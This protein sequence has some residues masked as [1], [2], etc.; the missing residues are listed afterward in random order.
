[1][2][3]SEAPPSQIA[4]N[5]E[6]MKIRLDH[7][8]E[9]ASTM[10]GQYGPSG[11]KTLWD[12]LEGQPV[13]MIPVGPDTEKRTPWEITLEWWNKSFGDEEENAR[14]RCCGREMQDA[15][16]AAA[17]RSITPDKRKW[18]IEA[19]GIPE[20]YLDMEPDPKMR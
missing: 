5:E 11:Y 6:A 8:L 10:V 18:A 15:L 14:A 17:R 3:G 12:S 4:T 20:A 7:I 9:V 19:L 16:I 1:M 13:A 2:Y